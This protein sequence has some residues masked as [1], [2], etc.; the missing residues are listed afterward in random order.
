MVYI[1]GSKIGFNEAAVIKKLAVDEC[2]EGLCSG[3][4]FSDLEHE[5]LIEKLP[6]P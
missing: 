6:S 5:A 4:F 2:E 1:Q 3:L